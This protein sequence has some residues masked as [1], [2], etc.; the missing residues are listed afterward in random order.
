M[1]VPHN[2]DKSTFFFNPITSVYICIIGWNQGFVY[3]LIQVK[4][5]VFALNI[6]IDITFIELKRGKSKGALYV[7]F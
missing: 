2:R 1:F 5:H 6:V 7:N 4:V 3:P